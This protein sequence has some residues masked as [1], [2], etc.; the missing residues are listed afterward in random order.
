MH[1]ETTTLLLST[2]GR[3]ISEQHPLSYAR[4]CLAADHEMQQALWRELAD[5]GWLDAGRKDFQEEYGAGTL[6]MGELVGRAVITLPYGATTFLISA[7]SE[8]HPELRENNVVSDLSQH[9]ASVRCDGNQDEDGWIDAYG[10]TA[11]Y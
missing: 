1:N 4:Q 8:R 10:P 2:F 3:L 5:G 11:Q 9:P 7:L 6:L